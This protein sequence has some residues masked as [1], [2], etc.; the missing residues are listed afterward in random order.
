MSLLAIACEVEKEFG[1]FME[2]TKNKMRKRKEIAKTVAFL[3]LS[4]IPFQAFSH[5]LEHTEKSRKSLYLSG[6][7]K[8]SFS[9]FGSL[10]VAESASNV[11]QVGTAVKMS[12]KGGAVANINNH[13]LF[14]PYR[15]AFYE[16]DYFGFS[17]SIGYSM[18][19]F[20]IEIEKIK[21]EFRVR[22]GNG[23]VHEDDSSYIALVRAEPITASNYVVVKNKKIGIS[24]VVFNVCYDINAQSDPIVSY[25]CFGI[26]GNA[27]DILETRKVTHGYYGKIGM[28]VLVTNDVVLFLGGYYHMLHDHDFGSL[29]LII[30][31]AAAAL[32]PLPT[33]AHAKIDLAY[34]GGEI[35]LRYSF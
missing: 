8:S 2:L 12:M 31:T 35:G 26:S 11:P 32:R 6:S 25:L 16:N 17:G 5:D 10:D 15:T 14:V 3:M 1:A 34:L 33:T 23:S 29:K 20:R 7:Y 27:L 4:L 19:A 30:P 13:G 24:S 21:S 9:N 28:G 22:G 18:G